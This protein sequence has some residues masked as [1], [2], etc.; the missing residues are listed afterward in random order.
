[1]KVFTVRKAE[2]SDLEQVYEIEKE[3]INSWTYNQ[4][5]EE[6]ER[7]FSVFLVAESAGVIAGYAIAWIVADELQ[8][9]SIAVSKLFRRNGIG[10]KLLQKLVENDN[11]M[12]CNSIL[13]EVRKNNFEAVIFYKT[14][15][16]EITGCRKNYY[17]DDDALL[18]EKKIL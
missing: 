1:M 5:A 8:L 7:N 14:E 12:N 17:M 9:N 3:S 4:F 18:M 11:C 2:F 16:F 15:G 13:I 10:T 6:L